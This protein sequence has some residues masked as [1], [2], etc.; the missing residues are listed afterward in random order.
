[1][2]FFPIDSIIAPILKHSKDANFAKW[3]TIIVLLIALNSSRICKPEYQKLIIVII[4]IQKQFDMYH[5]LLTLEPPYP[6]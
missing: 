4:Q 6:K 5:F 3:W 1:M 2:K